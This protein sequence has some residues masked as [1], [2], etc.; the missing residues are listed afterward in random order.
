MLGSYTARTHREKDMKGKIYVHFQEGKIASSI[1]SAREREKYRSKNQEKRESMK[2]KKPGE[3]KEREKVRR[4]NK[5]TFPHC[6][7][8]ISRA[9]A[10][11]HAMLQLRR[12][13]SVFLVDEWEDLVKEKKTEKK[14]NFLDE[15]CS[16][17]FSRQREMELLIC[18]R[19]E[20]T[21]ILKPA[22]YLSPWA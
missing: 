20:D 17:A 2:V 16:L 21:L 8:S 3:T 10:S 9:P 13:G 15:T 5:V 12:G 11:R 7:N 6:S 19:G 18:I 14:R 22:F 1:I 4:W